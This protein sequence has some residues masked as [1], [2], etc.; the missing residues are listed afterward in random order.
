MTRLGVRNGWRGRHVVITGGSSGIGRAL[1]ALLTA[2]GADVSVLALDDADLASVAI[3]PA[4]AGVAAVPVDVTDVDAVEAA[5]AQAVARHGPVRSLMTCAGVTRPGHAFDLPLAEYRREM[6]INYFGTLHAVRAVAPAM[7]AAGEGTITCISSAAGLLGV[8]G[9]AAYAPTKFAVRGLCETLR[10]ELRPH[11]VSVTAVY[12]P[13]V[14]TPM[15]HGEEP[16]KPAETRAISGTIQP[17]SA[18]VV[19]RAM[20]RGT[21]RGVAS[22]IPDA[23]TKGLRLI[24]GAAPG[25]TGRVLDRIIAKARATS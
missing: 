9:Y 15:L 13:D 16:L 5:V 23:K 22:V 17:L 10:Q 21:E 7:I 2:S 11:G 18:D 1:A 24:V 3:D 19:A 8:F 4:L 12:P 6:E 20:L 25:V 14:D